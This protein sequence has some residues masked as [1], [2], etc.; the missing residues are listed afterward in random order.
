MYCLVTDTEEVSNKYYRFNGEDKELTEE[1]KG[2]RFIYPSVSKF[3]V[4]LVSPTSWEVVPKTS[5]ELEEWEHVISF[6]NV[7]LAYEGTR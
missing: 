7:H 2:E 6:K 4:V 1:S 3:Q 5:I